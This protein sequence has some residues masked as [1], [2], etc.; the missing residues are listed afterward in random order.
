MPLR[1]V[2]FRFP[3]LY[4]IPPTDSPVHRGHPRN[5]HPLQFQVWFGLRQRDGGQGSLNWHPCPVWQG[6]VLLEAIQ[7]GTEAHLISGCLDW[8]ALLRPLSAWLLPQKGWVGNY[9]MPVSV[10]LLLHIKTHADVDFA[11]PWQRE[12]H[13]HMISF[14]TTFPSVSPI[15]QTKPAKKT[16]HWII[17][18]TTWCIVYY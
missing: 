9:S 11:F 16:H 17:N 18:D 3:S 6:S 4:P 12:T 2:C 7:R 15:T 14:Q 5:V 13:T 1:N 8:Q 10:L